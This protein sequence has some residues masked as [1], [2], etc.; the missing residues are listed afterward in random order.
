MKKR[1]WKI[2]GW[3]FSIV[4]TVLLVLSIVYYQLFRAE[5]SRI[6]GV[7]GFIGL[8]FIGFILELV[9]QFLSP[10]LGLI[11]TI[12]FGLSPWKAI[13][14]VIL[15]S[16]LGSSISFWIGKN[17]GKAVAYSFV[18][19]RDAKRFEELIAKYG[20]AVVLIAAIS[21]LPY[22]PMI[23]GALDIKWKSFLFFGIIPR[24]FSYTIAGWLA[25]LAII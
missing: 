25:A 15:G 7:Y 20:P 4:L 16:L 12:Y 5:M 24:I 9:P 11:I 14:F 13:L 2:I 1:G 21:P 23:A 3:I 18:A 22:L 10:H 6:V 17:Q 19:T 8:F